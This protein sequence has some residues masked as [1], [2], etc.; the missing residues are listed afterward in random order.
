[1][2]APF[3]DIE[4]TTEII[5]T[6]H[7]SIA[8]VIV[9]PLQR[10]IKPVG[11]FLQG[12]RFLTEKYHIVLIF[13]EI[14]TG[15]RLDYGGAQEH[16]GVVPDVAVYGKA[17]TG[18]FS[19][20]AICGKRE[21][22]D[23]TNPDRAGTPSHA[24]F[25]GTLNGNPLAAAA[26]VACLTELEKVGILK[27][28]HDR[29]E[30]FMEAIRDIGNSCGAPLQVAGDGPVMQLFFTGNPIRSYRD[31]LGQNKD[32]MKKVTRMLWENGIA[33]TP[34]KIYLSLAHSSNDLDQFLDT[35]KGILSKI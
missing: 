12:L 23:A 1:L 9:E 5:K 6:H 24:Y 3:N 22:L 15:F 18:G 19:L 35:L 27:D 28:L 4:T 32:M 26:G 10:A 29:G 11:A 30:K 25:S 31:T 34:A 2:I 14:V 7:E 8:A 21:I 13:D 20:A 16:Y 33:A 17:L